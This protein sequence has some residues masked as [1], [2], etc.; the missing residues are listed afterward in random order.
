MFMSIM[1]DAWEK[2]RKMSDESQ[3][4]LKLI[5]LELTKR[6][7]QLEL[8]LEDASSKLM[9]SSRTVKSARITPKKL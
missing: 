6:I 8:E 1:A 5:E 7:K 2:S 9:E 4:K 3:L